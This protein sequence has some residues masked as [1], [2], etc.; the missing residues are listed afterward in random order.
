MGSC[1]A[2]KAWPCSFGYI[3][4]VHA[5]LPMSHFT[6]YGA[7]CGRGA[8]AKS[9]AVRNIRRTS[10][11]IHTC[12]DQ[13]VH[14]GDTPVGQGLLS[15]Q[16]CQSQTTLLEAPLNEVIAVSEPHLVETQPK[17]KLLPATAAYSTM[18]KKLLYFVQGR[19]GRLVH[20]QA[21]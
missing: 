5:A 15:C 9:H 3:K 17:I 18:P 12:A 21:I 7:H 20:S 4:C 14:I 13:L 16:T 10:H 11:S 1:R 2:A 6:V 8:A 19:F